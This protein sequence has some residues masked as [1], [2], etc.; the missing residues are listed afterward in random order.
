MPVPF[1]G[2]SY[3][4]ATRRADVQRTV[5]MYL[6]AT[7]SG[8][9]KPRTQFYLEQVPGLTLFSSLAS[10]RGGIVAQDRLFVVS[11]AQFYEV[12]ADGTYESKGT[13]YTSTGVVDMAH[14]LNQVVVVDGSNGYVYSFASN[15]LTEI[16]D[17]EFYGS[18]RVAF[19]DGYFVFVRPDTQQFYISAID[20]ATSLDAL[21]FASA[22]SSPDDLLAV[23][24]DHRELWLFGE[25]TTEVW[26]N[27]GDADFPFARNQGALIEIG[28]S[29][30]HTPRKIDNG[31]M[32]VGRDANGDG[33][34][35][36]S[37]GYQA[38]RVSTA[39]VE[40]AL[41]GA[42]IS[43]ASAYCYQADGQTFYCINATG[44]SST[45]CY[46]VSSGTWHER[47]DLTNGALV[48]HRAK[49]HFHAFGKHLVGGD[50]IYEL[51]KDE[52]TNAG[53]VLYRERTSPHSENPELEDVAFGMFRLDGTVGVANQGEDPVVE[54]SWSND[55]GN[56]WGN[57]LSRPLGKVGK[58]SQRVDWYRLGAAPDRV[59]K[60][61]CTADV[62]FDVV[63]VT[64]F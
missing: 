22:E 2:P 28:T 26:Y 4:L 25:Y 1:V 49:H 37:V 35:Y 11:G 12:F 29:A 23:V 48:A 57:W 24:A 32:W 63:N 13:L 3:T 36:R 47:C 44:L 45:W 54:L 8:S 62:K 51:D 31:I 6:R 27:S 15:A 52:H 43:T 56:T 10:I 5:N 60:L 40:E 61:R 41:R 33:M 7:E 50:K 55:G 14:G 42:T 46:E 34:V 20:D 9:G 39:A 59:W 30:P 53:D 64:V 16:T 17:T 21:D 18:D 38:Q 19:L 58:Y